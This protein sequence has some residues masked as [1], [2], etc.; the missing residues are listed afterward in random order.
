MLK[1][2][3]AF[4]GFSANDIAKE[5]G[6]YAGTHGID[7]S[8]AHVHKSFMKLPFTGGCACGAIRY[9][10]NAEPIMMG[11]CHCRDCQHIS[12]GPFVPSSSCLQRRSN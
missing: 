8:E 9:E 10:C 4:S 5:K 7:V 12:G 3:K 1:N 2:S 6:F 11:K